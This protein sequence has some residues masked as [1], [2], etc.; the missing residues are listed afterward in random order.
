MKSEKT[1][2]QKEIV[3][4][5]TLL[6][7][8]LILFFFSLGDRALW[9]IDEGMHAATSKDMVLSGD[10]LTPQ[11]NGEKFYDKPPLHNWLVAVSFLMFGFTEFA[12]RL[13]AA[14][15]GL[16]CVM[17]TYLLGRQIFG[18][19][20]AFLSAVVL[21]T[22][23]E[24][25]LLSRVVVHD[26]SLAFFVTLALAL[27]YAGY[28]NERRRRGV[29]LLGYAALGFAVLAKGPV[30]VLLPVMIIGLFLIVTRQLRLV[31]EMQIGWGLLILFAVAAPWYILISLK[32][33]NYAGYFFLKQNLGNFFSKQVRH[34]EPIY[35]YIPVLMGGMLPWSIFLPLALLRG[36]RARG[37]T[38]NVGIRFLLIWVAAIFIFF[39][40]ASSKLGTYILP[41][42]PAA[43]LLVGALLH[44]LIQQSSRR[45]HQGICYA[46]LPLVILLPLALIYI[47]LFP[48][49]NLKIDVGIDLKWIY[50][51]AAWVVACCFIC[52]GLLISRKYRVF[53]VSIAATVI[54]VL[55]FF[56]LILVPPI[57]PFRSGKELAHTIDQLLEP[58]KDLVFYLKA[59]DTFLFYTDRKAI[60]LKNP[61]Q[62]QAYMAE[63]NQ[64]YCIF[65]MDDWQDVE[66]LH[67]TMHIV[68]RAGN[69]LIAS[70]KKP[71]I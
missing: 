32:D 52:M 65:K 68:A 43:A 8:C 29:F 58:K 33:P 4:I 16:G 31:K 61:G 13:P 50:L 49:L 46:Y 39:S 30:G 55:L 2:L 62:L 57:E 64:V 25:I 27:F 23:A 5:S 26:I 71:D 15:L 17:I 37:A 41:L 53:I 12:A 48:P 34:P 45:V 20:A 14:M 66:A 59:R 9:D 44:D 60:V 69:K 6:A 42:F 24:Y 38:D 67:Q 47:W 28:R 40:L 63:D 18:P 11:Y 56:L 36:F 10:W 35:Y 3:F 54:S 1:N 19:T 51:L 7:L 22:S 70:N 21:A